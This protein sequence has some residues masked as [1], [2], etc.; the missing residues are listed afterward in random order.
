[1]PACPQYNSHSHYIRDLNEEELL[2][3]GAM[4]VWQTLLHAA[5]LRL[6]ESLGRQG[7]MKRYTN[8]LCTATSFIFG[9]LYC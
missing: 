3:G 6:P 8:V 4:S 1:M 2:I 7:I 9:V 5:L